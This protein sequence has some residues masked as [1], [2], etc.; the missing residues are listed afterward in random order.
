MYI[1]KSGEG[2]R[3]GEREVLELL[4]CYY[5]Y[6]V[7]LMMGGCKFSQV[8]SERERERERC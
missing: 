1:L 2:E 6:S 3:E 7:H 8:E 4:V 5:G